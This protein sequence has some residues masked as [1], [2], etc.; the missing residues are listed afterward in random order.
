MLS[1]TRL[2]PVLGIVAVFACSGDT[3]TDAGESG[4]EPG[5][6]TGAA[7]STGSAETS[8]PGNTSAPSGT[9][10]ATSESNET[11]IGA[12]EDSSTGT[13]IDPCRPGVGVDWPRRGAFLTLANEE[14][15][16]WGPLDLACSIDRALEQ[17]ELGP[18]TVAALELTCQLPDE[19]GSSTVYVG[20]AIPEAAAGLE[21]LV[22]LQDVTVVLEY[23]DGS[24]KSPWTEAVAFAIR[25]EVGPLFIS[26][27]AFCEGEFSS[28]EHACS[29][30][31]P[32]FGVDPQWSAPLPEARL[33][34]VD[35]GTRAWDWNYTP[36]VG[37]YDMTRLAVRLDTDEG[38][39]DILDHHFAPLRIEGEE[40]EFFSTD[41]VG[42][43]EDPTVIF[44]TTGYTQF[45]RF[46]I[47]RTP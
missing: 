16:T 39:L 26:Q 34:N 23:D 40:Y 5:S 11:T 6:T 38:A 19:S 42:E 20:I 1:R 35:C 15:F 17:A 13:P 2:L 18:G 28:T 12:S 4:T 33:A 3:S 27:W 29:L 9:V 32:P 8:D 43:V 41:V 46:F 30:L 25:D 10:T 24:L 37:T 7:S 31:A 14:D 44:G 21:A 47:I 36:P 22:G 45:V